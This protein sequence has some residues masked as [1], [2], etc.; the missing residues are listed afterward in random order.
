MSL[1][2]EGGGGRR[3]RLYGPCVKEGE[4]ERECRAVLLQS[5][6]R[7]EESTEGWVA[8]AS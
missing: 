7:S 3:R 4:E 2:E 1:L 6:L 8:W 5:W